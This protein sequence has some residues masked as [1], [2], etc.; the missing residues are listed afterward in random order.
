MYRKNK[1]GVNVSLD[2]CNGVVFKFS[3]VQKSTQNFSFSQE[4][5]SLIFTTEDIFELREK[6]SFM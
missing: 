3:L 4:I 1:L 6:L 5:E 2:D